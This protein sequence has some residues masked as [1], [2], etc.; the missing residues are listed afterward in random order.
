MDSVKQQK[1]YVNQQAVKLQREV[2]LNYPVQNSFKHIQSN[3]LK[4]QLLKQHRYMTK[5]LHK[6]GGFYC[7]DIDTDQMDLNQKLYESLVHKKAAPSKTIVLDQTM[8]PSVMGQETTQQNQ[9]S[10][11]SLHGAPTK[12]TIDLHKKSSL[13]NFGFLET[14]WTTQE[15][16]KKS[17]VHPVSNNMSAEFSNTE[18]RDA[19]AHRNEVT[20]SRGNSDAGESPEQKDGR[21]SAQ[22]DMTFMNREFQRL[23]TPVARASVDVT[24]SKI[25]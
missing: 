22:H 5:G 6:E 14:H 3:A 19:R 2:V 25:P 13:F 18:F 12:S 11:P 4:N 9:A 1:Q 15:L 17:V 24:L 10:S 16:S 8:L 23:K 20:Q 7:I 21:I